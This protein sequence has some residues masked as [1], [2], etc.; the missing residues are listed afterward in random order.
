MKSKLGILLI[1]AVLVNLFS[2]VYAAE[3]YDIEFTMLGRERE[4]FVINIT[5]ESK[6]GKT[7][8]LFVLR[9]G[10]SIEELT[11]TDDYSSQ[12]AR[13]ILLYFSNVRL[14]GRTT[15]VRFGSAGVPDG[16]YTFMALSEDSSVIKQGNY[17][18]T[19]SY[20]A[21]AEKIKAAQSVDE[22]KELFEGENAA[23]SIYM[24]GLDKAY[25]NAVADKSSAYEKL[26]DSREQGDYINVFSAALLMEYISEKGAPE[27]ARKEFARNMNYFDI[28]SSI[29][30]IYENFDINDRTAVFSSEEFSGANEKGKFESAF[31]TAVILKRISMVNTTQIKALIEQYHKLLGI[32]DSEIK[33][34]LTSSNID[35]AC[36]STASKNYASAKDFL[37]D[38]LENINKK[39][40]GG[41]SGSSSGSSS[42]AGSGRGGIVSSSNVSIISDY[43]SHSGNMDK[44]V[45]FADVS[46]HW[47]ENE[48]YE[49]AEK[50]VIS[51]YPNGYF[52][53]DEELTRAQ[54]VKMLAESAGIKGEY[55]NAG[56]ADVSEDSWY[57][58]YVSALK[59]KGY[60]SGTGGNMFSPDAYISRQD[61]CVMIYNV[62]GGIIGDNDTGFSDEDS[63][64]DYAKAAVKGLSSA[65]VIN[66]MGNGEFAPLQ[67]L[68]R[69]QAAKILYNITANGGMANE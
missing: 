7:I 15:E 2:V 51:G 4:E 60:I 40:S 59:N 28:D 54:L 50:K 26:F 33:T 44:T 1:L 43:T 47:A 18:S 53:P 32:S 21:F 62:F 34:Y 68:T 57:F 48:I 45:L 13:D 22:I 63:I 69:A 11:A 36:K 17:V 6:D 3:E 14:S 42:S 39:E 41:G 12:E 61:A 58:P 25:F 66:G 30:E 24:T 35:E 55:N 38:F 9:P 10:R 16:T 20:A 52:Y 5:D 46:G 56:F 19:E 67:Y 49:L 8:N 37:A 23:E 29:A 31:E 64:A 65:S 27:T